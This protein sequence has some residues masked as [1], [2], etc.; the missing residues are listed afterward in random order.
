VLRFVG[1]ITRDA[2]NT[3]REEMGIPRVGEGWI[4]ETELYYR[5]KEKLGDT[6]VVHHA[7]P[8][9]LCRQHLDIFVPKY[10]V[11]LEFQGAQH[12][13]P[14][15]YFG[16]EKAFLATKHRD[17]QKRKLCLEN[18]VRLLEVRPGYELG[19][20]VSTV[21]GQVAASEEAAPK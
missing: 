1:E 10:S 13:R 7:R 3:V 2:E 18:G 20:L 12:D 16:G 19:E 17:E 4:A 8:E 14:V 11:A 15:E 21:L 6:T 5:L 9:W